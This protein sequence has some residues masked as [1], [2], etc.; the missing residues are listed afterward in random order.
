MYAMKNSLTGMVKWGFVAPVLFSALAV[1][2]VPAQATAGDL[3]AGANYGRAEMKDGGACSVVGLVLNKGYTCSADDKNDAWRLFGGYEVI[4][5]LAAEFSY[6]Q[7]ARTSATA[8]GTAK[9]TTTSVTA[10]STFRAKGPIF[11]VVGTLPVTQGFGLIGRIGIFH[12]KV[13]SAAVTSTGT[14]PISRDDTKPGFEI[15]NVGLGLKYSISKIMDVRL[16]W[17]RYK[18]V[19]NTLLTGQADI[20]FLS[21]GLLYKF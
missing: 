2:S 3:Y 14:N 20:D 9:G 19:G 10:T 16:E 5:N 1:T 17:D 4:D 15:N 7:F 8:S 6:A 18:D 11:S 21:L 13:E 12:W